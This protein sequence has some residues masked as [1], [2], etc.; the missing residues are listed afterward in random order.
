MCTN[1]STSVQR[2]YTISVRDPY[3]D[4]KRIRELLLILHQSW[5]FEGDYRHVKKEVDAEGKSFHARTGN[6]E[7]IRQSQLLCASRSDE[8][9]DLGKAT[10][11]REWIRSDAREQATRD[12][13]IRIRG[14]AT[15][16][17]NQEKRGY[18]LG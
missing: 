10:S 5:F 16:H 6:S 8:K 15:D 18:T 2:Q 14:G 17:G 11:T 3:A 1:S 12:A 13:T 9:R 4:L 7:L